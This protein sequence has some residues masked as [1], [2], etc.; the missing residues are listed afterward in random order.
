MRN[1]FN[2]LVAVHVTYIHV[3]ASSLV[4]YQVWFCILFTYSSYSYF[5]ALSLLVHGRSRSHLAPAG[6][7][8][9]AFRR[10]SEKRKRKATLTFVL[11]VCLCVCLCVCLFVRG[12][13]PSFLNRSWW[14][15]VTKCMGV[16]HCVPQNMSQVRPL[17]GASPSKNMHFGG[18]F[19]VIFKNYLASH[20]TFD[21]QIACVF[22]N[23]RAVSKTSQARFF[24]FDLVLEFLDFEIWTSRYIGWGSHDSDRS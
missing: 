19:R 15:L 4:L 3:K 18:V 16:L 13:A 24:N 12:L 23:F 6:P 7:A 22:V 5:I 21:S 1:T 14:N 10:K 2:G 20:F 9:R 8:P 11:S 17:G